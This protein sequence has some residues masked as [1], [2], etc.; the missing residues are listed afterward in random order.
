MTAN[1]SPL[2]RLT[3]CLEAIDRHEADVQAWVSI[4]RSGAIEQANSSTFP[5]GPLR[6]LPVGIKDIYDV[7]GWPTHPGTSLWGDADATSD[8][9]VVARLRQA[10]A[11][12]LGKAVTTPFAL[13]DPP[14]TRNPIHRDRTPGGSSSGSAAAVACGM[15]EAAIGSQTGGSIIRPAAYCGVIGFKP[16]YGRYSL[17]GVRPLAP[18]LDHAGLIVREMSLLATLDEVLSEVPVGVGTP[19]PLVRIRG[20]FDDLAEPPM[21]AAVDAWCEAR[22]IETLRLPAEFAEIL[23]HQ[24]SLMAY[25]CAAIHG[26]WQQR[27]PHEYPPKI[28]GFLEEGRQITDAAYRAAVAYRGELQRRMQ[29]AVG[30]RIIV[31]PATTGPAPTRETTGSPAMQ[32]PWSFLGWP[33][34]TFPIAT[35][36]DGLPLG[37]QLVAPADRDR[38]LLDTVAGDRSLSMVFQVMS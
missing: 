35:T 25:E 5:T 21:R 13:F 8:S 7:A 16:T 33:A 4:D 38:D 22:G 11:I 30:D 32:S 10:G 36:A 29:D 9:D 26:T 2:Q 15:C 19:L 31:C 37:L 14:K 1:L 28:T 3:S 18:S 12:V 6:G 20:M 17:L 27:F 23:T 34:L 24:K